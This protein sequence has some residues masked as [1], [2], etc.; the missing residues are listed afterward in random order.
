MHTKLDQILRLMENQDRRIRELEKLEQV[1]Q[2]MTPESLNKK[3][4]EAVEKKLNQMQED[5]DDKE[6]RRK[7]I[8]ISNIVECNDTDREIRKQADLKRV[9][10]K[11]D[12]IAE[13]LGNEV[14]DPIRLGR[15]EAGKA[16][17]P[18]KVTVKTERTKMFILANARKI[19]QDQTD[20]RKKVWINEDQTKKER[21]AA[22]ALREELKRRREAGEEDIVIRG[23]RIV[24]KVQREVSDE[25]SSRP[26]ASREGSDPLEEGSSER[27][28]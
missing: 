23:V 8:I 17:R 9:R 15:F 11:L 19:K 22:K 27:S 18:I 20:N 21:E 24:K 7:N 25:G 5:A 3:I 28:H 13:G 1:N 16:P 2:I 6:R 4:E 14:C 10:A 26:A 12:E